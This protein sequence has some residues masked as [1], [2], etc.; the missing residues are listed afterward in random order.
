MA[1]KFVLID[2]AFTTSISPIHKIETR[3]H[4]QATLRLILQQ[5]EPLGQR[6]SEVR[7]LSTSAGCVSPRRR[8]AAIMGRVPPLRLS[9]N[10]RG[11]AGIKGSEQFRRLRCPK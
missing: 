5:P 10:M 3:H 4:K 7:G 2:P 1:S 6:Q 9:A 11:R 8:L